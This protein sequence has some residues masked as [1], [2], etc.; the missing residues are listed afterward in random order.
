M[1]KWSIEEAR[2]HYNIYGWGAGYFDINEKGHVIAQPKP[3]SEHVIDLKHLVDDIQAKGYS[4][5][6]LLR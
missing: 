1:Q 4:L 2:E 5:P 6:V 3:G